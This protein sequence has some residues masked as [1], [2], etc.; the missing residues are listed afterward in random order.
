MNT[1][2]NASEAAALAR[3][4]DRAAKI[5]DDYRL[6]W[7]RHEN[8]FMVAH[9][10][11][12]TRRYTVDVTRCSCPSYA[13]TRCCKHHLGLADLAR[14]EINR[15]KL[16]DFPADLERTEAFLAELENE[17]LWSDPLYIA[18]LEEMFE[19]MFA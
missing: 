3:I 14:V 16:L 8:C 2:R 10:D 12:R 5:T 13:K 1:P 6:I 11:D 17:A 9:K 19:E 15:Y 4:A 18:N 7:N